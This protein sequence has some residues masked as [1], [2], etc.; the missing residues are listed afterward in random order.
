MLL[1]QA[2]SVNAVEGHEVEKSRR[3]S[4][5]DG[6]FYFP[7]RASTESTRRVHHE[8]RKGAWFGSLYSSCL[9]QCSGVG[10]RFRSPFLPEDARRTVPAGLVP[11]LRSFRTRDPNTREQAIFV[12][13]GTLTVKGLER[14]KGKKKGF[15]GAGN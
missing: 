4:A 3:E 9:N 13:V 1:A 6:T 11:S 10:L 7:P 5:M 2:S 14:Q 15:G 12:K 8:F